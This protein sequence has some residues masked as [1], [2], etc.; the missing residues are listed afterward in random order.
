MSKTATLLLTVIACVLAAKNAFP[1]KQLA[2]PPSEFAQHRLPNPANAGVLEQ[3]AFLPMWMDSKSRVY[4]PNEVIWSTSVE[5]DSNTLLALSFLSPMADSVTLTLTDSNGNNV[6][7]TNVVASIFPVG[8]VELPASTWSFSNPVTGTWQFQ[9]LSKSSLDVSLYPF[10]QTESDIPAGYLI[11]WNEAPLSIYSHL[12]TYNLE[13]GQTIGVVSMILDSSSQG[14][15]SRYGYAN[16]RDVIA[17]AV[18]EVILPDGTEEDVQMHDDGLHQ[19]EAANDGIYGGILTVT[20]P[21]LY[22]IEPFLSGQDDQGDNFVRTSQHIIAT[23]LDYFDLSET[24]NAQV[25]DGNRIA[26]NIGVTNVLDNIDTSFRAYAEVYGTASDGS[27]VA[28]CWISSIVDVTTDSN[29]NSFVTLNLDLNWLSLANAQPPL[30]LQ[31]VYIQESNYFIPVSSSS[32]TISVTM[33]SKTHR[34]AMSYPKKIRV[35]E[36]SKEMKEGIAPAGF[37]NKTRDAGAVVLLHGYCSTENPW[38]A[39]PDD[40]TDP[41]FFLNSGASITNEAF[42]Q[43]VLTYVEEKGI[44]AFSLVG[45]S[46]GGMVSAHINTYYFSGL[47]KTTSGGRKIQAIGTPFQGC[48]AAGSA[49]N[50]GSAFGVGCGDNFDLSLDGAGLWLSGISTDARANVY[51]YTTTYKLGNLFGDSCSF[52]M[53]LILEWPNDGTSELDYTPLEGGNDMGNTQKQCHITGLNYPAQY[54][55]HTRNQLMNNNAAR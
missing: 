44:E 50:L 5:V 41:F 37:Y 40:W 15:F 16:R 20:E 45:H 35:T 54:L 48:T 10:A 33:D 49:A 55:D 1:T 29:G 19:D 31:N 28:V 51:Y 22:K 17:E 24:A 39:F 13:V 30:S 43:K 18:M 46:Q 8:M 7:L 6:P 47:D 23:V 36:I 2:G 25:I 21:G 12:S 4:A 11:A 26:I 3:S 53:N 9:V 14:N 38:A 32:Q 27:S 34:L 52:A 42:S